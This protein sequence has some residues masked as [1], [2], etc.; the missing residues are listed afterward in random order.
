MCRDDLKKKKH[1]NV[2][3]SSLGFPTQQPLSRQKRWSDSREGGVK[4]VG[5]REMERKSMWSENE[6]TDMEK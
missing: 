5:V 1:S 3:S 2:H 6:E 4:R